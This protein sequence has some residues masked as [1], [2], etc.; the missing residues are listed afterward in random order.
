[1]LN[2]DSAKSR[3]RK[4]TPQL[5]SLGFRSL[6]T[7]IVDLGPL[8]AVTGVNASA[9][10]DGWTYTGQSP[11]GGG[12]YGPYQ[13]LFLDNNG[14]THEVGPESG[15]QSSFANAFNDSEQVVGY[16]QEFVYSGLP[17]GGSITVDE[18][19]LY[20]QGSLTDLGNLGG[21]V[22]VATSIDSSGKIIGYA[23]TTAEYTS[24]FHAVYWSPGSTTPQDLGTL[25]GN[26]QATGINDQGQIVGYSGTGTGYNS[27][28]FAFLDSNGSMTALAPGSGFSN[29]YATGINDSGQIVGYLT[30][31]TAA[32]LDR[33]ALYSN[34][35]WTNLGTLP[36][37][38]AT[39]ATAINDSGEVVGY[40][41]N[42]VGGMGG[43]YRAIVD[44]NGQMTDLN[45]L[46]PA[47]SGWTLTTATAINNQGVIVGM[48]VHN[49]N[50][51]A[52]LLYPS[53]STPTPTPTPA[54]APTPTPTPSPTPS[55]T[56]T[57]TP[58]PPPPAPPTEPKPPGAGLHSTST[59]LTAKPTHATPGRPV[60]LTAMVKN[61]SRSGGVP[62]GDVTFLDGGTILDE[63]PLSGGK[64]QL[65][66]SSLRRGR[67]PIQVIYGG[68]Q[69]F[70]PSR[71][72][73]LI[74]TI[75]P[76]SSKT[77]AVFARQS[78]VSRQAV[79][80]DPV[81]F[82]DGSA[83]QGAVERRE[84]EASSASKPHAVGHHRT[85]IINVGDARFAARRGATR[86]MVKQRKPSILKVAEASGESGSD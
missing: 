24:P 57:P 69:D 10:I 46:L 49:G 72:P 55:P 33:A 40:A 30:T 9:E 28:V 23:S 86:Q 6:P 64:A 85:R 18:A 84:G 3:R 12:V 21:Y 26:S 38:L 32:S 13:A 63:L 34:G 7:S 11:G 71:S 1:M 36:G 15:F 31:A 2:R 66:I 78:S 54:P 76:Q 81:S 39:V 47:N 68:D 74:E 35:V 52:Y 62:I 25:G 80:A 58:S 65:T 4:A 61:R 20:S 67:N 70:A 19:F 51:D 8:S 37:Y 60:T 27:P 50:A 83:V 53:S 59:V 29:S 73:I 22:S 16:S 56:P 42:D 45:T 41:T 48:G 14:V 44:S 43:D 79:A 17:M 75:R 5:E 77:K 82:P